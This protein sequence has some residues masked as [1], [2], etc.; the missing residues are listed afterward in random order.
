MAKN[1]ERYLVQS[2]V[3]ASEVLRAFQSRGELLRLRDVVER[4]GF[5]KGLC[6][7]LLHTLRHCGLLEKIDLAKVPNVKNLAARF[8]A[9]PYDPK[10]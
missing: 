10:N 2:V 4:T 3:H 7:R 8:R 9:L 5:N 6:F 1:R